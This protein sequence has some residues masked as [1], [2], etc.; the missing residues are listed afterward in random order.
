MKACTIICAFLALVMIGCS[1]SE[2]TVTEEEEQ[3]FKADYVL[4]LERND[5]LSVQLLNATNSSIG[6]NPATSTFVGVGTPSIAWEKG[7][8][9]GYYQET[10][11]CDG[12]VTLHDF[13]DD[14]SIT[15][16]VFPDLID[17]DLEVTSFEVQDNTIFVTYLKEETSKVNKYYVRILELNETEPII[18]DVELT[19]KP[20]QLSLAN[21]RLFIL[22][23]DYE[24]TDEYSLSVMQLSEKK[25]V[26]EIGLG[27]DV[28]QIFT[29]T[30]ENI[31]IS[32]QELHTVLN[33]ETMAVNYIGY[34]E[35]KE[36]MFYGSRFNSFDSS[37][38][39]YYK[40]PTDEE[41]HLR[42]P[43]IYDFSKNLAIIYYYEN[44]LNQSQLEFEFKIGATTMVS[45][46]DKNNVM[47]VGYQKTE[48]LN[49]GGLL[50]I[51]LE[52]EPKFI[53][54]IDLDGV[55]SHIFYQ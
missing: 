2:P 25:L 22:T 32:Y 24:I 29:S 17:C 21:G 45:Y 44:F 52:P 41:V 40:R 1:K 46:D 27:Y 30:D 8:I 50:R 16:D 55:P 13:S 35:G 20:L 5:E 12:E 28:E 34:E 10:S 49:G 38:N 14:S 9:F 47:L 4:L 36:P 51:L 53:D 43:A 15:I 11:V 23:I 3:F 26:L 33:S 18:K 6:L 42:T 7:S 37:G 39:L 19:K 31:I 54:N 48:N